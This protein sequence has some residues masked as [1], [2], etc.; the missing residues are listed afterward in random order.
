MTGAFPGM[1]VDYEPDTERPIPIAQALPAVEKAKA[2]EELAG[3]SDEASQ[4]LC[5]LLEAEF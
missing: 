1:E 2:E 3:L 4:S 5:D